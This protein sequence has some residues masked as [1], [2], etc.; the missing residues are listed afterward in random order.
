MTRAKGLA[1][2]NYVRP[3]KTTVTGRLGHDYFTDTR[4]VLQ[5]IIADD[6]IRTSGA[7]QHLQGVNNE[8]C[9]NQKKKEQKKKE[10]KEA[11][12]DADADEDDTDLEDIHE[13]DTA[14][15]STRTPHTLDEL[16]VYAKHRP[17]IDVASATLSPLSDDYTY[18]S[19]KANGKMTLASVAQSA[20]V[21][22][23]YVALFNRCK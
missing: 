20:N 23:L 22:P 11:Q 18:N 12:D 19:A 17:I 13:V 1:D 5:D 16:N 4:A 14:W 7:L 8:L 9:E 10:Q 21:D 15:V 2:W 3:D 6:T